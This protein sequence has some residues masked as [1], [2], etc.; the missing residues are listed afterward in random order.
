[1]APVDYLSLPYCT[2]IDADNLPCGV[3]EGP[4]PFLLLSHL[5]I[6]LRVHFRHVAYDD[7]YACLKGESL[8][9]TIA[10]CEGHASFGNCR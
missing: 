2:I 8:Q 9:N 6:H 4:E 5:L 1:M 10:L 3:N 7:H